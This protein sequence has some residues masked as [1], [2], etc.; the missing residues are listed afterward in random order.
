MGM[1]VRENLT[2]DQGP[3]F[4][5]R[6]GIH[7]SKLTLAFIV[8]IFVCGI[9]GSGFLVYHFISC[10]REQK[11]GQG[12]FST[13]TS[14]PTTAH[15]EPRVTV[16]DFLL[17]T[18]LKPL[19]YDL[20]IQPF[21][22]SKNFTFDGDVAVTVE[23]LEECKNITLHSYALKIPEKEIRITEN[24]TDKE[25]GVTGTSYVEMQHFFVIKT[26]A[27]LQKGKLYRVHMKFEGILNEDMQG[28]YRSSY[29]VGNDT[30]WLAATQFQPTDARRTFPCMDQPDMK[31][32]F[33]ITVGRPKNMISLSNMRRVREASVDNN[34]DY[35]WDIYEESVPMSTYLV[36]FVVCD[37]AH[38]TDPTGTLSVWA[39]EDAIK[40]A[41]YALQIGPRLLKYL[42]RFFNLSYPL[43]KVDM[44]ALPDF[45]AGAM[46]NFGLITYRE[47]TMLFEEGISAISN[48]QRVA[49][50]ISHELAHQ[51]FGNMVTIK[52]WNDL[53]LNEGFASYME[54]L[55]VDAVEPSWMSMDL[56]VVME[57]HA[58]FSLDA[59]SSSHPISVDV[60]NPDEISDI[61]D[62][63]SYGKGAAII[64]MM[65]HFLT[66]EVFRRGLNTYLK[67][68]KYGSATQDDLWG[69][70][71]DAARESGV[72]DKE[73]SVKVIMDTWTLQTGFP[74]VSVVRDYAGG[75]VEL[76][77][78]RFFLINQTDNHQEDPLW[79][80]P[81]TLTTSREL[82][83]TDTAPSHW[84][85]GERSVKLDDVR[86]DATDWLIINVQQSGYYRVNYD[87]E[88]WR[89]IV[90]YLNDPM[91]FR[92]I[93]P[94]NRAQLID[95]ALNLARGGY[96]SYVTA[97]EVTRYLHHETDYVPWKTAING[98]TFIESMLQKTGQFELFRRYCIHL[99]DKV[100]NEV[101]FEDV[102]NSSMLTV[103][104][105]VDILTLACH[106]GY[107][108]CVDRSVEKFNMWIHEP[109]PDVHNTVSPNLKS[110]IY[111]TAIRNGDQRIWDFAW[112]RFQRTRVASEKEILL[113]ALGCSREP[114]I[115]IRY[116][117]RSLT[118]SYGIRKQD[119]FRVFAA[120]S[121]T[122]I[123]QTVTFNYMRSNWDHIREYLGSTMAN[124][125]SILKYSTRRIN[126]P[127]ELEE[128]KRFTDEHFRDYGRSVKQVIERSE[129]N[130]S[131]MKRN[132]KVITT[133]LSNVTM[134]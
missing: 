47:A 43:D 55:G 21:F 81:I 35:L 27:M 104:K 107:S 88:N 54:Y 93:A 120:V 113:S 106:L 127:F 3:T 6:S 28:F 46:E 77:Q 5:N 50:V 63:I 129:A 65:D 118:E 66:S 116:L 105:R 110:L 16:A 10:P 89:A 32:R 11:C 75:G 73:T 114:W 122:N 97:L 124:L 15:P 72:F 64:R 121:S 99:L 33:S 12:D 80:I 123:G 39:R 61:F 85:R 2:V 94:S 30:R 67:T 101:G 52:W 82:N 95:D 18:A 86:I 74:V 117:D 44:I 68:L 13:T 62:R 45:S 25:I 31:A 78:K 17:P 109:N 79:W 115:L 84:M 14:H 69:F 4:T 40:S 76:H 34:P 134:S 23:V 56:F 96:L 119:V 19:H 130:I 87:E 9:V 132:F 41:S 83:F 98:L 108:D 126:T 57:L 58:V 91:K 48:K 7:I 112:E 102:K 71:T 37:F 29:H 70:L 20:K 42:E 22:E 131:W 38:Q 92:E 128:L 133:W 103:Y 36:A 59:L 100:Y 49:T 60:A 24:G 26:S 90:T 8:G 111:C 53:W 125:N 51:W 1:Q